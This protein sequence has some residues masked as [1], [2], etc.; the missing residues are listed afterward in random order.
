MENVVLNTNLEKFPS[1]EHGGE[2]RARGKIHR[3]GGG[4]ADDAQIGR[5]GCPESG[6]RTRWL[7]ARPVAAATTGAQ[8]LARGRPFNPFSFYFI[9]FFFPFQLKYSTLQCETDALPIPWN[10]IFKFCH[11]DSIKN[12]IDKLKL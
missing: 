4:Q 10:S 12:F 9:R 3:T 7:R 6:R 1:T 5:S 2:A 8:S 11:K